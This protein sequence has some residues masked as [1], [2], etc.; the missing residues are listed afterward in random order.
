[1]QAGLLLVRPR[2]VQLH[3]L[4]V[5][6][7]P[8]HAGSALPAVYNPEAIDSRPGTGPSLPRDAHAVGGSEV[9][10]AKELSETLE[11]GTPQAMRVLPQVWDPDV[12]PWLH[13]VAAERAQEHPPLREVDEGLAQCFPEPSPL[14]LSP[15]QS[16]CAGLEA[17]RSLRSG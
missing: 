7:E 13:A 5:S 9:V 17:P 11:L 3:R 8:F 6:R 4:E 12:W 15:P 1:M 16:V 10:A 14:S 2:H